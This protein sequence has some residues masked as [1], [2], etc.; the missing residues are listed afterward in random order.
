[1]TNCH[2]EESKNAGVIFGT[3]M[4]QERSILL[5]ILILLLIFSGAK[6]WIRSKIMIRSKKA[7][8]DFQRVTGHVIHAG[9]LQC[10]PVTV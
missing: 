1:M 10:P 4:T 6:K 5:L 7:I 8:A 3:G 9:T 2:P